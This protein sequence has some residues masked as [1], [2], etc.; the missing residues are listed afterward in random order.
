MCLQDEDDVCWDRDSSDVFL[1]GAASP[2]V[3]EA[4]FLS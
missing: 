1:K 4:L 3:S 2:H